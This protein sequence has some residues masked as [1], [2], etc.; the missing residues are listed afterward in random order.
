MVITWR[1]LL[2]AALATVLASSCSTSPP[3]AGF[4]S[5]DKGTFTSEEKPAVRDDLKMPS[6]PDSGDATLADEAASSPATSGN[7]AGTGGRN[8]G[9]AGNPPGPGA[10]QGK[11]TTAGSSS[12]PAAT[13]PKV[14]SSDAAGAQGGTKPPENIKDGTPRSPQ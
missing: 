8:A 14:E 13:P 2:S 11:S 7:N 9:Q 12:N 3:G 6:E 10:E 4:T 1:D 5:G